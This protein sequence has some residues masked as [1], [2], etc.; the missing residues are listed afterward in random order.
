MSIRMK[1]Q[2]LPMNGM[3]L[4]SSHSHVLPWSCSLRT[5]AARPG[6]SII[7]LKNNDA[8]GIGSNVTMIIQKSSTPSNPEM[9]RQNAQPA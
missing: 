2:M 9:T 6:T 7:R 8:I 3:K 4:M 1:Y 5:L